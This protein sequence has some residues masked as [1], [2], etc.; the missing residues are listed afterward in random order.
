MSSLREECG[1]C[2]RNGIKSC[3]PVEVPP[4]NFAR[5]DKEMER[6]AAQEAEA[7]A[8]EE[9]ALDALLAARAKKNRLR[10]QKKLL[11]RR[12]QK[13]FADSD[14]LVNDLEVLE[15]RDALNSEVRLLE[16]GLMPGT[17]A[18]DWSAFPP[19]WL[20]GDLL[21]DLDASASIGEGVVGNS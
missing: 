7:D 17:S 20:D 16:E 19:S 13:W 14:A 11:Q 12:E 4:P 21:P 10:K 18:L 2:H 9:A 1:N 6:L 3:E 8:A 5:L 15:A